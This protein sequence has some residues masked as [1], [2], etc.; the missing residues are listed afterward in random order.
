MIRL[1]SLLSA[2]LFLSPQRAGRKLYFVSNLS[3]RFS[4]YAMDVD[5]GEPKPLLPPEIGLPNPAMLESESFGLLPRWGKILVMIDRDGDERTCPMLVPAEGGTP[6]PAFPGKLENQRVTLLHCDPEQSVVYLMVE[7]LTDAVNAAYQGNVETGE[8]RL[9]GESPWTCYP[10]GAS[11]SHE[12]G[13]VA[14]TYT[15]GD[16]VLYLWKRH[17]ADRLLLHGKPMRSRAQGEDVVPS[18]ISHCHVTQDERG[19]LCITSLF[20]DTFGLGYLLLDEPG[21]AHPVRVEGVVHRGPGELDKLWRVTGDRYVVHFNIDGCSWAYEGRFDPSSRNLEVEHVLCG[22]GQLSQG[23]LQSL[24]YDAESDSYAL[25]FSSATSPVQLYTLAGSKRELLQA[26]TAERVP[27]IPPTWLSPG[28]DASFESFDGERVSARLYLPAAERDFEGRRPLVYYIHGGP[29]AQDRPDFTWFSIP[30]IQ[31][32]TLLGFAVFVPN[33]RGSTGYGLRYSRLV[34]R[35]WGG[36]D[37]LDHVRAM[38]LLSR[39]PRVDVRRAA[40][41]GRSYGGY[42]TLTLV[43][44]HPELWAAAVDMFGPY[45]LLTF[46]S[47]IPESWK[48]YFATSTGDPTIEEDRALLVERSPRTYLDALACPLLVIQGAND[49]RVVEIESRDLVEE[50][51]SKGKEVDYLVFEDEGHDFLKLPNRLRCYRKI[52]E[53]LVKHLRP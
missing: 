7:S 23:V 8:L 10:D 27:D 16:V 43:G 40:V 41:M 32:L 25:A 35:D 24:H 31:W 15:S 38:E 34:D 45:N 39:D 30:L 51:R 12:F 53:F 48:P 28:E 49:P 18:G 17:S 19:V 52:A 14:E 21:V 3:G 13:L 50:M 9:L 47:R 11:S 36:N 44:R 4:L 37:R 5:G 1:E 22:R 20:A 2:R 33:V 6:T 26:H 42:M 29:Q 46:S